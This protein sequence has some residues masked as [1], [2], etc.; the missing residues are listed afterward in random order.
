MMPIIHELKQTF[1]VR[2]CVTAQHREMLDQVLNLFNIVPDYDLDIMRPDQDLFDVT[3]EVLIGM[4]EIIND[5]KP[6]ILLVHGDTT[7]SVASAIAAFYLKI[8]IG[9]IEAGLRTFDIQS[10]FPEEMNR[11]LTSRIATFHFAPTEQASKNLIA[12][13]IS[14]DKIFVTGNTV[15]DAMFVAL[16][17]ARLTKFSSYLLKRLNFL[18]QNDKEFPKIILVTGHRRENFGKGFEEICSAIKIIARNNPEVQIVYPVHL[19]PNVRRPVMRI[20]SGQKNVHIIEPLEY[21]QFIK[22]MDVC[23]LILT[24]S[25]GIQEEAPSIG[26][27]VLLMRD[28]TERPEAV[29]AGT[30]RLV[31]SNKENIIEVTNIL[32]NED[33]EYKK[34]SKATNPYGDGNASQKICEALKANKIL[35]TY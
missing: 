28:N 7:T 23:Y 20:L 35:T 3:S 17:R 11:Q 2:V 8:H 1:E 13:N 5:S 12:E 29:D 33:L 4:K 22:L 21:L 27:P 25:G 30:V 16:K 32:L 24:D 26:K 6:D 34:M 18:S 15:I 14:K 19:N 31:G 9:H 10:P